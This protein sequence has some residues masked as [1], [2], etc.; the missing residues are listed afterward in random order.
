MVSWASSDNHHRFR[1]PLPPMSPFSVAF[2]AWPAR[3]PARS[4]VMKKSFAFLLLALAAAGACSELPKRLQSGPALSPQGAPARRPES[5]QL[6]V[7][8]TAPEHGEDIREVVAIFNRAMAVKESPLTLSPAVLGETRWLGEHTLVFVSKEPL[9]PGR[10]QATIP[11]EARAADGSTLGTSRTWS[12]RAT[13]SEPEKRKP[14]VAHEGTQPLGVWWAEVGH[15]IIAQDRPVSLAFDGPVRLADVEK[16]A[17]LLLPGGAKVPVKASYRREQ[18]HRFLQLQATGTLP[19]SLDAKVALVVEAGLPAEGGRPP[20]PHDFRREFPTLLPLSIYHVACP[21]SALSPLH[22]RFNDDVDAEKIR[23][24]LRIQPAVDLRV[25]SDGTSGARVALGGAFRPGQ[26]YRLELL[27]GL[28][29]KSTAPS[30]KLLGY[31]CHVPAPRPSVQFAIEGSLLERA[32]PKQIPVWTQLVPKLA[33]RLRLLSEDKAVGILGGERRWGRRDDDAPA[34]LPPVLHEEVIPA[35]AR[36]RYQV[37]VDPSPVLAGGNGIAHIEVEGLG[38]DD[39]PLPDTRRHLI[40]NSTDFGLTTKQGRSSTLV[41]VTRLSSGLPVGGAAVSLRDRSGKVL[42]TA[43]TDIDGVAEIRTDRRSYWSD[44]YAFASKDGDLAWIRTDENQWMFVPSAFDSPQWSGDGEQ[45]EWSSSQ[46]RL[47]GMVFSERGIYRPGDTVRLK[48]IVRKEAEQLE[49]EAGALA[50]VVV[51]D[52]E[53]QEVFSKDL[54]LSEFGTFAA[55]VSLSE[56]ATLGVY[57]V[58]VT[59]GKPLWRGQLRRTFRVEE[60]RTPDFEVKSRPERRDWYPGETPRVTVNGR[61]F[62]GAAMANAPVTWTVTSRRSYFT[63]PHH[64]GYIWR[65]GVNPWEGEHVSP[66]SAE[67]ASGEGSLDAQGERV[68]EMKGAEPEQIYTIDAKVTG[69]DRTVIAGHTQVVVHPSSFYLGVLAEWDF[70][71]STETFRSDLVAVAPDGTRVSG[72]PIEGIIYEGE[73]ESVRHIHQGGSASFSSRPA[74]KVVGRCKLVSAAQPV[75]CEYKA[76][77]GGQFV[78]WA[79][80]KDKAGRKVET[81]IGFWVM[82]PSTTA[83]AAS[84]S[85]KITARADRH[86]YRLGNTARIFVQNPF[87]EA[88]ALVT[89]ERDRILKRFRQ[90]LV[91][92][93]PA[94]R[95]P[96]TEDFMPNVY[97]SVAL[98]RGRVPGPVQPIGDD[99]RRPLMRVGHAILRVSQESRR[100]KVEVKPD[101]TEYRPG[102]EVTVKLRTVGPDGKPLPTELTLWAVDEGVLSLTAYETPDPVKSFHGLRALEIMTSDTRYRYLRRRSF[103]EK[104][105]E[106][107]GGGGDASEAVRRKVFKAV[108]FFEPSL[109]TDDDGEAKARFKLPDNMTTFRIMAVA[110]TRGQRFG[111]GEAKIVSTKRLLLQPSLPR[112]VR[113]GDTVEAG[114]VIHNR[115]P[116]PGE[117]T[118]RIEAQGI[119]LEGDAKREVRI[120]AGKGREVRFLLRAEK[121]GVAKLSFDVR[122]GR[123]RDSLEVTR[124]VHLATVM[125]SVGLSGEA[126]EATRHTVGPVPESRPDTGGLHLVLSGSRLAGL[127]PSLAYLLEYPYGCA[128]QTTSRLLPLLA[129]RDVAELSGEGPRANI[130][131]YI[132]AGL[133]RLATFQQPS[134]GFAYWPDAGHV[135]NW[136]TSYVMFALGEAKAR[137]HEVDAKMTDAGVKYL[138]QLLRGEEREGVDGTVK[139]YALYALSVFGAAEPAYAATLFDARARLDTEGRAILTRALARMGDRSRAI[140]LVTELAAEARLDGTQVLFPSHPTSWRYFGSDVR[141]QAFVL[142]A[143]A[144]AE[145]NHELIPRIAESI[146]GARKGGRWQTTQESAYALFAL[147]SADRAEAVSQSRDVDVWVNGKKRETFVF[148]PGQKAFRKLFIPMAELGGGAADLVLDPHGGPV[149]YSARLVYAPSQPPQESSDHGITLARTYERV[150]VP[151]GIPASFAA[152]SA[153]EIAA[154][155][156]VRVTL[157][158][159]VSGTL[160]HAVV[161]DPLPAGLEAVNLAL[162]TEGSSDDPAPKDG[163]FTHRELRDDRV[164]LYAP[165]LRPG[166]YRRTYLAR[167]T[168]PGRFGAPSLRAEGMYRPEVAG[169]TAAGMLTVVPPAGGVAAK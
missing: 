62:F 148:G 161:D 4:T 30:P 67:I 111:S 165:K 149:R 152:G 8:F 66:E 9:A 6:A 78:L 158:I 44:S 82:G 143:L 163:L 100:A 115:T 81:S 164:V 91:G 98:V 168:T 113:A 138:K 33:V 18:N 131:G 5:S 116:E 162:S 60:F 112:F 129:L 154:G 21:T 71:E 146:L 133:R 110:A 20:L 2:V 51:Q 83:W 95:I 151:N 76:G 24:S 141:T 64:P 109:R 135:E 150:K 72:I 124:P 19:K 49:T 87:P 140:A 114:V 136:V 94:L 144:A 26:H 75:R 157:H 103:E 7:V 56:G 145:P 160:E 120:E 73:W 89:I 156:L 108:A 54:Q 63:P 28:E 130:L 23:S 132:Q 41:W 11:A 86:E 38:I 84:D 68:I 155:D 12:F 3:D 105:E 119:T 88:E 102:E 57:E 22:I 85:V 137:G 50:H 27:A 97:V 39:K 167:A 58:V 42:G 59:A 77:R 127:A 29:G 34:V 166:L 128:E 117:A 25:V 153:K 31:D 121:P 74:P 134:G 92:A 118:V 125:Q 106:T 122:L 90:K 46:P 45:A 147:A 48:G 1:S 40:V 10:Y 14:R 93:A 69:L 53:H 80:A 79:M 52:S 61:Y 47:R 35:D 16:Y 13:R 169:S 70:M 142:E 126:N 55:D 36:G 159:A 43:E 123:E 104:G 96:V 32:M 99:P 107:G 101:R 65:P 17:H 37:V 15:G 139:A